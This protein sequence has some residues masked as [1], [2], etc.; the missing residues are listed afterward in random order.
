MEKIIYMD[1]AATT[2][3]SDDVLSAMLPYFKEK[4]GNPST[5]YSLGKDAR[6][7]VEIARAQVAKAIGAKEKEIFFT[8]CGTESD[9]WAIKGAAFVGI[10]RGKIILSLQR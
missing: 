6:K 4:F 7:G 1:N 3:V 8:S 9:N 2:S 5:I 10:K